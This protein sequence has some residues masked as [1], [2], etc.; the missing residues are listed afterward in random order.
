MLRPWPG[1]TIARTIGLASP[2]AS[3]LPTNDLSI[4]ILSNG[5][6]WR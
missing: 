6:F 3:K 2:L 1:F 4:L 5:N